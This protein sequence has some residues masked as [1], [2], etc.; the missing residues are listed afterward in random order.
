MHACRQDL[1]A[2][3]GNPD[4][5]GPH[6]YSPPASDSEPDQYPGSDQQGTAAGNTQTNI[7]VFVH[8]TRVAPRGSRCA[9][10]SDLAGPH[11]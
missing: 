7:H 9:C 4:V 10:M 8:F 2:H 6:A 3:R 5:V 11:T 1:D